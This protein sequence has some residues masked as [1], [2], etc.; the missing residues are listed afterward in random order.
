MRSELA[1]HQL[2]TDSVANLAE[3]LPPSPDTRTEAKVLRGP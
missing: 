1:G 3:H 2:L